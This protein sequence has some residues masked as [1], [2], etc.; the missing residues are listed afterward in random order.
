MFEMNL[1][2]LGYKDI[3]ADTGPGGRFY[4]APNGVTYPS[5]TT[6]LSVLPKDGLIAW[7]ARVGD[8]EADKIGRRAGIRGTLVHDMME[9]Y[10][11][12]G[13]L[14]T[15]KMMPHHKASFKNL[16][17]LLDGRLTEVYAQEAPLYSSH[18]GTA[19]RVDLVGRY[20]G[21]RSIIDFKTSL[22]LKKQE[23]ITSYFLQTCAYSIMFEERTGIPIPGIAIIMDVDNGK[24]ILFKEHRDNWTKELIQTVNEYRRVHECKDLSPI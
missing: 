22:R 4:H 9:T 23:W 18:L 16:K 10:I 7:R 8:A 21:V 3:E 1:I 14:D 20:D 12:T 15:S 19:G 11:R 2:D 5:I 24:P 17:S 6:V 13:E